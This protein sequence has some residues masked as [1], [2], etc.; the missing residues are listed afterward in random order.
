MEV[1][2]PH[3]PTQSGVGYADYVFWDDSGKP[4]AVSEAKKTAFSAEKGRTQAKLYADGLEKEHGQRPVI[5]YT[6][7]Y[8]ISIWDDAQNYPPRSLFGF[9]SKDSLE[10]L[11]HYQRKTKMELSSLEPKKEIIGSRLY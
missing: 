5:F 6:N 10:Y 2:V 1:E 9:Y 11:V 8:D 7:G 3:Q 4:L